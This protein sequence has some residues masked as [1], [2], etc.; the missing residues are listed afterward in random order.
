MKN[1]LMPTYVIGF[2][3]GIVIFTTLK[4]QSI[5]MCKYVN[6]LIDCIGICATLKV[7]KSL[8]FAIQEV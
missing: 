7:I 5:S 8:H 2:I 4:V 3:I 1:I 6:G